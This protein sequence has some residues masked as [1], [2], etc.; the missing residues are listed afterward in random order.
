MSLDS[1][2]RETEL[3][4]R[5]LDLDLEPAEQRAFLE[6]ECGGDGELAGR[7]LA[8]LARD[9]ASASSLDRSALERLAPPGSARMPERIGPY[10]ILGLLGTGGMGLVYRAEQ[11]SPR[12]EV[13]LKV[14][15]GGLA[16]LELVRRFE[17]EARVLGRLDHQ[18][19]ARVYDAG[20]YDGPAGPEP[21]V[22]MELVT[23]VTLL[24]HVDRF[25]LSRPERVELLARVCDAVAHAH[26]QGIVHR[27]LKPT[28]VLVKADGQPK[29]LDFGVAL[30]V[31]GETLA[32]T[33]QTS[34]G[35]LVGTLPYMSP[36]QL[37][38]DP[39]RVDERSDVYALGVMAF[40]LLTG[41][42]PHEVDGLSV[43]A[44][45]RRV[46]DSTAP[47][48]GEI[49][50]TLR[51]DLETIVAKALAKD[52]E[53]RYASVRE[54]GEDLRRHLRHEPVRAVPPSRID[55]LRRFA[56]RNPA[57]A[58]SLG[59]VGLLLVAGTV[60]STCQAR[61]AE[62]LRDLADEGARRARDAAE[63]AALAGARIAAE[64]HDPSASRRLL[65]TVDP[66]RRGWVW[67]WL[68]VGRDDR[69][70]TFVAAEPLQAAAF[71]PGSSEL[72]A[73]DA[74]GTIT[75]WA[76]DEVEGRARIELGAPLTGPAAFDAEGGFV[77]GVLGAKR[78][79]IA[80]WE[81]SS[82]RRI[83]EIPS[84]GA[85]PTA[86]AVAAGGRFVAFGGKGS[87]L[88]DTAGTHTVALHPPTP[89]GFAF[90][91]EGF[92]LVSS[93]SHPR[94]GPG[95]IGTFDAATGQP[96]GGAFHVLANDT[97]GVAL[98][99][100]GF[101]A[102]GARNKRAYLVDLGTRK[103]A[104]ELA[105]DSAPVLSLAFDRAGERVATGSSNGTVRVWD[106]RDRRELGVF[107][108]SR[109]AV[110]QVA[111]SGDGRRV[112]GVAGRELG[113]WDLAAEPGVL[114]GHRSFVYDLAFVRGGARLV[115]LSYDGELRVWDAASL[116][117]LRAAGRPKSPPTTYALSVARDG[118]LLALARPGGV[119]ILDGDSLELVRVLPLPVTDVVRDAS[120]SPDG[121][122]L[123][124]LSEMRVAVFD[125]ESGQCRGMESSAAGTPYGAVAFSPDGR[126]FAHSAKTGVVVRDVVTGGVVA[127][128]EGHRGPVEALAF[129]PDGALLASGSVDETVRLWD[130]RRWSEVAV[131]E[132]HTDRV[133]SLEFSP[134]GTML[135]SGSNDTMI[136]LWSVAARTELALLAGH[137]DYVFALAFDSDGSRLASGSGD[138]TVRLWD[139][140]SCSERWRAGERA[141]ARR[142]AAR[143]RM[144]ERWSAGGDL[145]AA[146]R[147]LRADAALDAGEREACTQA[148]LQIAPP[149]GL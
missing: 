141:R 20:V 147:D 121:R 65:E 143:P 145:A 106:T 44:A 114:R 69:I 126:C 144:A 26:E 93:Y 14:I 56:R 59:L 115:S 118:E 41:R 47:R 48:L 31:R 40:E 94:N 92:E 91:S 95:W 29:V 12:R 70:G 138:R 5:A 103:V 46:L 81:A 97:L 105:G 49:D 67:N 76:P 85:A 131:L 98:G 99:P 25:Q 6:R 52:H 137:E 127:R 32:S 90:S 68:S 63:S 60:V 132:G 3:F 57:L 21:F 71:L 82:G 33:R 116:E 102:V 61:R 146:M 23:G 88:W 72:V 62:E 96:I 100:G 117:L 53:L 43:P 110:R 107:D 111:F 77:A 136:R 123:A 55:T 54:L 13:A 125:V 87:F 135:A 112:L 34:A 148:L 104:A 10:R 50:R 89:T 75:R 122:L 58:T 84:A 78:E 38:G 11:H 8:L 124:A 19:I 27:D 79:T 36:E 129:A 86:I 66:A 35:E 119:E 130:T 134:D 139:T 120:F 4:G 42:R 149:N 74:A 80:L 64:H 113:L 9:R 1:H 45:A 133:Y 30:I 2:R 109:A 7:V 22:A 39:R 142:E 73:V 108:G 16:S 83:A 17:K 140:R 24:D 101:V 37:E 128:L 28:N 18:G 51:G 15:R